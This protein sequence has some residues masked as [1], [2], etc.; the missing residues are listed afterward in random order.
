VLGAV[1]RSTVQDRALDDAVRTAEVAAGIGIIP[2]L[3]AEDLTQDFVPLSDER[4]AELDA[5]LSSALTRNGIVRLKVWNREHWL[6]YSD[7]EQLR[8]RWFP[9]N[10]LLEGSFDGR[11]TSELT[12]LSAP[13]EFEERDFG[14][15]LAVYVPLHVDDGGT[16]NATDGEVVGA[17]EIYLPYAPIAAA[18]AADTRE[19]YL[20]L[21]LG[22]GLL[23]VGLFQLVSRASRRIRRQADENHHQATHDLLTDLPNRR[24]LMQ[25]LDAA[26]ARDRAGSRA[27]AVLLVD[28][29][30]FKELNDALG[31]VAGDQLLCDIGDR[32]ARRLDDASMVA[33]LGGDEFAV[34]FDDQALAVDQLH[35]GQRVLDAL[36]QP[37]EIEG[38]RVDVA[39]SVGVALAPHHADGS[40]DLVRHADVAMYVAKRARSGVE[41]YDATDDVF[42]ARRLELAAEVRRAIDEHELVAFFQPKVHIASGATVGAE[43]LVRW[44]HPERGLLGPGEFMPV[45]ESTELITPLTMSMLDMALAALSELPEANRDL[46]VAVNLAAGSLTDVTLP[47]QVADALV[48]HGVTADRLELEITETSLLGDP[49]RVL[50][51]LTAL[52]DMGVTLAVDDF[53][54]GYASLAYLTEL[55]VDVVK[56]D[57]SFVRDLSDPHQMAVTRYSI[58]LARTLGLE[59]VAEGVEDPLTL[60]TLASLGC[61][62]AQGYHFSRPLPLADF[63]DWLRP[64]PADVGTAGAEPSDDRSLV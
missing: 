34:V 30:R 51:V 62:L 29:D 53:G 20:A 45:V 43:A 38:L 44:Q 23:Y 63:V 14:E 16:L 49:A 28:L 25:H 32:L 27:T 59:T 24:L 12:D 17:F 36:D 2:V 40:A 47:S 8:T 56:I 11:V 55:P 35:L 26:V 19:L 41:V 15:L 22:L 58:E 21:A 48:R 57:Q 42:D 6:V 31:H 9:G 37:F 7:N 3:T 52:S 60:D 46:K 50:R 10:E 33:R 18:I 1:L 39:A 13:E 5:A 61:D 64:R 4:V 54:T